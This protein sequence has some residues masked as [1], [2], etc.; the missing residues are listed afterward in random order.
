MSHEE[1]QTRV[2]ELRRRLARAEHEFL[3]VSG[4]PNVRYLTGFTGSSG[5]LLVAPDSLVL[6]TDGRY[7][8]Q[9]RAQTHN[10]E[11]R[12]ST[13]T[14]LAAVV[15]DLKRRRVRKLAFEQNRISFDNYQYLR[16]ELRGRRFQA[17]SGLVENLRMIKSSGEIDL[18]RASVDLNSAALDQVCRKARPSWS[19]ARLASEIEHEMRKLG[20]EGAAFETIAAS[21]ERSALP[22]AQPT[23]RKLHR[24]ALIVVDHGAILDGYASDMTRMICFGRVDQRQRELFEAV[25]EAQLAAIDSVKAGVRAGTVDRS[26]RKVLKKFKLEKAFSHSTGHGLGLEIHEAPRIG[27]KE[28][29]RLRSGMVITIEPGAYVEGV[30]GVRIEDVVAVTSNGCEVLTKTP[31]DLRVL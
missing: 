27:P 22:H 8:I 24:N 4:L 15:Q 11:V 14:V 23:A 7:T 30:G 13:G 5:F 17:L 31:R 10:V 29:L 28:D 21:R 3:L 9:A 1:R 6:Y 18:I 25:G 16:R 2:T 19:E 20:A 26:A 12:I